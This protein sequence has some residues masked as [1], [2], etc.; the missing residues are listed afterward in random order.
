MLIQP[1]VDKLRQMRLYGMVAALEE[2]SE[3]TEYQKLSL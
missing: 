1:T 2:Q 3:N